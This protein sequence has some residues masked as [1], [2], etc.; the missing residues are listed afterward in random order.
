MGLAELVIMAL[1]LGA[2]S[3][4]VC[5]GLGTEPI[6]RRRL[7]WLAVFFGFAQGSLVTG[8]FQ[9]SQV[10][11]IIMSFFQA[12]EHFVR[13]WVGMIGPGAFHDHMQWVVSFI[14]A[15]VLAAIGINLIASLKTRH[16]VDARIYRGPV[17]LAALAL[18]VN[19]DSFTAGIALGM[20]DHAMIFV[21]AIVMTSVGMAVSA[22]GLGLG[23]G[24]SARAGRL[25]SPAGGTLLLII[26]GRILWGLI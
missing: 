7:A 1:A 11:P 14:A 4:S 24:L 25:A 15:V 5:L 13:H 3:F 16:A 26:A 10:L 19:L 12:G 6:T 23:R 18:S 17:G 9:A 20:L 2:D 8:G 21:V 22:L